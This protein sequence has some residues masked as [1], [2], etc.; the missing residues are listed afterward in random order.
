MK[1]VD[2]VKNELESG[3]I[4]DPL[5]LRS[6]LHIVC[7]RFQDIRK[8]GLLRADPFATLIRISEMISD[9]TAGGQKDA[10]KEL[11]VHYSLCSDSY[12]FERFGICQAL[13]EKLP[14]QALEAPYPGYPF[15]Q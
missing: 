8:S 13:L 14:L 3:R 4:Q 9:I 5:L 15:T 6:L 12:C 11:H 10:L 1:L 2:L 7:A